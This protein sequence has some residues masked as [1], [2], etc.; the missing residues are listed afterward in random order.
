M[1]RLL[2]ALAVMLAMPYALADGDVELPTTQDQAAI[3]ALTFAYNKHPHYYEFGGVVVKTPDGHFNASQPVSDRHADNIEIDEDPMGYAQG[4]PIVADYHTHPCLD[5]Y[6]PGVFSA[7]DLR[8]MRETQHAGY[9][10]D[11]CTGDVHFWKPGDAYDVR[12]ADE[13]TLDRL[14]GNERAH[15]TAKGKIVGHIEVD[16]KHIQL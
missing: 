5:G 10:L 9:I 8:S 16:G 11:E 4:Y 6:V 7:P 15:L 13:M 14:F 3:L 12:D 1:T 2:T